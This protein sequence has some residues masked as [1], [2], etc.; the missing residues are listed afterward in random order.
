MIE[1]KNITHA[2]DKET[3]LENLC[4]EINE[5]SIY[6]LLGSNGAGKSTLLNVIDGI[7]KPLSGEVLIN[8]VPTYENPELKSRQTVVT[9]RSNEFT[10]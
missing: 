5:G 10:R 1:I 7:F 9:G 6:G 8:G 2:Y 3:V 4:S